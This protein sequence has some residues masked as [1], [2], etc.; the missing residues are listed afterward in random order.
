[1]Y[2]RCLRVGLGCLDLC[3]LGSGGLV[4]LNDIGELSQTLSDPGNIRGVLKDDTLRMIKIS[5]LGLQKYPRFWDCN[6]FLK[7]G[8]IF[9][10]HSF[11]SQ[12]GT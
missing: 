2:F 3:G 12:T 4:S 7:M 10:S 1:M 5:P 6:G 9:S 8:N 11:F